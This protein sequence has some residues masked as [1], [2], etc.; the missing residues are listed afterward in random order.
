VV[1]A[2]GPGPAGVRVRAFTRASER[3][4]AGSSGAI[5]AKHGGFAAH[6]EIMMWGQASTGGTR[7]RNLTSATQRAASR[8]APHDIALSLPRRTCRAGCPGD[9]Q[10]APA[11]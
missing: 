10:I 7:R 1:K 9:V 8:G 5:E 6:G 3:W 4:R 11:T 2:P